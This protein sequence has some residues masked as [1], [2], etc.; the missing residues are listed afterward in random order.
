MQ[1]KLEDPMSY[2]LLYAKSKIIPLCQM[3]NQIQI[4]DSDGV[5]LQEDHVSRHLGDG[6]CQVKICQVTLLSI[7]GFL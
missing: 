1:G 2:S 4:T 3:I 6:D 5:T 7:V